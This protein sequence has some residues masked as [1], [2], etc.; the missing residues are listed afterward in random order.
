MKMMKSIVYLAFLF[1][2]LGN[3][4]QAQVSFK[5]RVSKTDMSTNE[6]LRVNFEISSNSG[7]IDQRNFTPPAF[8]GFQ[9]IMGPSTSQEYSYINGQVSSKFVYG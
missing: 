7:Q 8:T 2:S 6:R 3:A 5:T 4:L 9:K 1:L